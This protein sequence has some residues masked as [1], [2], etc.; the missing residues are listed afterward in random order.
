MKR[1]TSLLTVLLLSFVILVPTTVLAARCEPMATIEKRPYCMKPYDPDG[2]TFSNNYPYYTGNKYY[3]WIEIKVT[4]LLDTALD[5]VV[6]YDRLGGEF[7]VNGICMDQPMQPEDLPNYMPRAITLDDL[8]SEPIEELM[9]DFSYTFGYSG[10]K[11]GN[12]LRDG[13][14]VVADNYGSN[15]GSGCVDSLGVEFGPTTIGA[16]KE[17]FVY[18]TGNS[19]KAHFQWN[20]GP[21]GPEETR[22][23]YL[24]V[25][26]DLNPA[27]HQEFTSPGIT[28]LNSGATLKVLTLN[29]RDRW[30]PIY[31]TSTPPIPIEVIKE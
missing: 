22:I 23:I 26:T 15:G 18:W 14:V 8:D 7:M 1:F 9:Q 5:N 31:S 17:F 10:A 24:V 16:T 3:W 19:C 4:N 20:I 27:G 11:Y 25:S 30:V 6:V 28:Y 21:M 12:P 2:D 29:P 13:T